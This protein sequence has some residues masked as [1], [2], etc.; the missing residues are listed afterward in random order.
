MGILLAF[1]FFLNMIGALFVLPALA[2]FTLRTAEYR[3][4]W[5]DAPPDVTVT[6]GRRW[7]ET[8][9]DITITTGRKLADD[10]REVVEK[11]KAEQARKEEE[12]KK[13]Q[14]GG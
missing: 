1:M 11:L 4:K 3:E 6:T 7:D 14:Q 2:A 9:P 5:R 12:E 10:V 8:H 13:K